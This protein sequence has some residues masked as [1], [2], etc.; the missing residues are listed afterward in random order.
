M[1]DRIMAKINQLGRPRLVELL[2]GIGCACFD[3]ESTQL[4]REAVLESVPT[5]IP[6]EVLE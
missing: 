3:D 2:E 4:L 6:E 5:D 1:S